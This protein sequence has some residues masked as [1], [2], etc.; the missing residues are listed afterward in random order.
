MEN[1]SIIPDT[2]NKPVENPVR[3]AA[4]VF[5]IVVRMFRFPFRMYV[6][7]GSTEFFRVEELVVMESEEM[8]ILEV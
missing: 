6:L 3:D 2:A 1:M 5:D 8:T 4:I 7:D